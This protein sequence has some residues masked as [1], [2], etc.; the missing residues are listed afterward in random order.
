MPQLTLSEPTREKDAVLVVQN[1]M[2]KELSKRVPDADALQL[3]PVWCTRHNQGPM[4]KSRVPRMLISLVLGPLWL[5]RRKLY[6][7]FLA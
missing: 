1:V 7:I 3:P 4:M 2:M 5:E 6:E